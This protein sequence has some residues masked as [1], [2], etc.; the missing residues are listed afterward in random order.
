MGGRKSS[1]EPPQAS[2]IEAIHALRE[3][4]LRPM[5]GQGAQLAR[6][7]DGGG[8]AANF[9]GK[10]GHALKAKLRREKCRNLLGAFLRLERA[11]A[12]EQEPVR[13]DE[14]RRIGQQAPL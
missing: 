10:D 5:P 2:H 14:A 8:I 6:R 3:A 7:R 11:G 13:L 12:V 9:L 4:S 1:A